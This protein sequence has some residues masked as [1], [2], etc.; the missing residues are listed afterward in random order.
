MSIIVSGNILDITEG[1]IIHQLNCKG[2]MGAGLAKQIKLKWPAVFQVYKKHL[3]Q[4]GESRAL[5]TISIYNISNSIHVV[6]LYGQKEYGR[7]KNITYTNYAAHKTAWKRI[8]DWLELSGLDDYM[9]VYA[10]YYIGAGLANGDW[11]AIH[12]IAEEHLPNIRWVKYSNQG[13][14][15]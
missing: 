15:L 13:F 9:D 6:N 11:Q 8:V 14:E 3:S 1:V 2:V 5:G 10:P 7:A 12:E 4:Q